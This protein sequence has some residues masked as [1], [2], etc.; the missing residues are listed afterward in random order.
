MQKAEIDQFLEEKRIGIVGVSRQKSKFGNEI[1]RKLKETGYN[2]HPVHPEMDSLDG[3]KCVASLGQLPADVTSLMVVARQDV[4]A[5]VLEDVPQT[6]IRRVWMFS[7][8]KTRPDVE[9]AIQRTTQAG[10]SVIA[11]QCPLLFLEPVSSVHAFH[12]FLVR[13][14]GRYPR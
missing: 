11:G 10:V 4:C 8:G 14:F 5:K 7:S 13:L 3:D 2:V 9:Q 12:R 1:Y 6:S